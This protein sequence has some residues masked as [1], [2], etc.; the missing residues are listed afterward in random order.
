MKKNL[1]L[2]LSSLPRMVSCNKKN[3][4]CYQCYFGNRWI[5]SASPSFSSIDG[6]ERN[7]SLKDTAIDAYYFSTKEITSQVELI[8]FRRKMNFDGQPDSFQLEEGYMALYFFAQIPS[9]Y[10]AYKRNNI[11]GRDVNGDKIL[12]T[13]NFFFYKN[14]PTISICYIDVVKDE[15]IRDN[16]FSFY[17]LLPLSYKERRKIENIRVFLSDE[18]RQGKEKEA[19]YS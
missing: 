17:Y 16:V 2:F 11:Q 5:S 8:D 9:G 4:A 18:E 7:R 13:D 1:I 19:S 6:K 3:V 10:K 14:N 12:L 15:E